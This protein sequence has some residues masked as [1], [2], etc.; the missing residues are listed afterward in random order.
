MTLSLFLLSLAFACFFLAAFNIPVP[1]VNLV[2]A[3]LALWVLSILVGAVPLHVLILLIIVLVL[4]L[5]IS[6]LQRAAAK[7][8]AR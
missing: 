7:P 8:P 1:V 6:L 4:V 3:G 2:A 5:L